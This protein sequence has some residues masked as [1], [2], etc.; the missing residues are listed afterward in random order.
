MKLLILVRHA[1]SSWADESLDDK[2]RPLNERGKKD[3]PVMAKRLRKKGIE[4]DLF[5]S[6]PAKR[7][8]RT[9]RYFAEAYKRSKNDVVISDKLY[10][11]DPDNFFEVVQGLDDKIDSVAIFSHNP[12]ITLFANMLTSVKVDNLPTCAVFA[13]Q[14]NSDKWSELRNASKDFLFFDYPKNPVGG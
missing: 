4:I 14:I 11:A 6:S 13:V 7:A 1:K 9:A 2:D 12:G 3:A 5:L 8:R 10:D